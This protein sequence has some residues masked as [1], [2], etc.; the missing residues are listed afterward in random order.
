MKAV[1]PSP[2]WNQIKECNWCSKVKL[3]GLLL[4]DSNGVTKGSAS[5]TGFTRARY[6]NGID[7][8]KNGRK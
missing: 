2:R 5:L 3:N 1:P 6:E 8:M 7:D 4:L